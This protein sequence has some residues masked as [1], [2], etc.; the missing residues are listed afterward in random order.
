LLI[1]VVLAPDDVSDLHFKVIH[2]I[3]KMKYRLAVGTN[4]DE[5]RVR[6]LAVSQ[7]AGH[8][9][10]DQIVDD[11][12]LAFHAEAD[13]AV[14]LVSQAFV[15]QFVEAAVVNFAALRLVIRPKEAPR[16]PR[17]IG[18]CGALIPIQAEPRQTL[19]DDFGGFLRVAGGIGVF[20]SQDESAAG[21]A[22]VKPIE[23]GRP[24][25]ADVQETGRTGG[26][27]DADAHGHCIHSEIIG[28]NRRAAGRLQETPTQ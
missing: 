26:E 15:L 28:E 21:M 24:G 3:D 10:D 11:N 20:D 22:G 12:R 5:I 1:L 8:I 13:R 25:A 16:W 23:K 4:Y 7:L 17:W 6:L 19:Q 18:G 2:D 14:G 9:A 27:T